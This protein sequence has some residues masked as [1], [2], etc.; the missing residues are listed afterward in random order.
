M[1][2]RNENSASDNNK[3]QKVA[4]KTQSSL[5][6]WVK[7]QQTRTVNLE[8]LFSKTDKNV[9]D[10]LSLEIE[11]MNSEWLRALGEEIQKKYFIELKKFLKNEKENHK[12]FPPEPEIYSWSRYT[13]PSSVKVVIIGQD[14]YH[15]D[16][17]AHGLCFSVPEGVNPPPSLVNIYKALKKDIPSFQIPKHGN[18]VN[19]A[20]AGVL[21]LNTSLTVRAHNAAS[22]SGKGW[23]KFTDAVIQYLSEKKHELVFMLWGNHAIKKGKSINNKK[24][25]VLQSVHPSPLSAHRG[26][27]ECHHWSKANDYLKKLGKPEINWNCLVETTNE[28]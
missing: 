2:K 7:P 11:T 23:E 8:A 22:H 4:N 5:A 25:L 15:D 9:K 17:Q 27:F 13:P 19:W 1:S 14:P 18:L 24:H 21:L 28:D 3:K 6:A 12:I 10:I 16:G 26:F 20:K